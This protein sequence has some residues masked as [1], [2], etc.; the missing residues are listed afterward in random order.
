LRVLQDFPEDVNGGLWFDGNTG[1]HPL[2]VDVVD[3]LSG[4]R[5]ARGRFIC[6]FCGC[7]GGD[8][9]FIMKAVEVTAG[10]FEVLDPSVWLFIVIL[11]CKARGKW[12]VYGLPFLF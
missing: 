2:V 11:L 10:G 4:A 7:D 5:L 3:Q 8:G 6:R 12:S 1:L 9:G